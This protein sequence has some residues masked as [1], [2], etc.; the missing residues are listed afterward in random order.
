MVVCPTSAARVGLIPRNPTSHEPGLEAFHDRSRSRRPDQLD[1]NPKTRRKCVSDLYGYSPRPVPTYRT[2]YWIPGV[3]RQ[4]QRG[5]KF[6]RAHESPL[7]WA[8]WSARLGISGD[9]TH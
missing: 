8:G 7:R 4:G 9:C 3:L 6:A 2:G 5:P 1:L